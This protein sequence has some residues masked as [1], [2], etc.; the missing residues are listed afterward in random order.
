MNMYKLVITIGYEVRA[1][2]MMCGVVRP[3]LES[4]VEDVTIGRICY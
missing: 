4:E 3:I 1:T 2:M